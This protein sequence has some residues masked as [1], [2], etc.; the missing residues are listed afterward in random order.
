[1]E[2]TIRKNAT[3]SYISPDIRVCEIMNEKGFCQSGGSGEYSQKWDMAPW[4]ME[5]EI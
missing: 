2:K 3:D 5:E 1:M 4:E